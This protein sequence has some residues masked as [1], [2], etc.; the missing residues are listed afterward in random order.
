MIIG[1]VD[2]TAETQENHVLTY[3]AFNV[4]LYILCEKQEG[5]KNEAQIKINSCNCVNDYVW[6]FS[7]FFFAVR[8]F[9]GFCERIR[10]RYA[11]RSKVYG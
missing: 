7:A 3:H 4:T 8:R 5:E 1:S 6:H 2:K 11:D 9:G 10:I